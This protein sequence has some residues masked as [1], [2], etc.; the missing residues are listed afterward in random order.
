M[1]NANKIYITCF[2]TKEILRV[3]A[4][5]GYVEAR[6]P[7]KEF[8]YSLFVDKEKVISTSFWDNTPPFGIISDADP[9]QFFLSDPVSVPTNSETFTNSVVISGINSQTFASVPALYSATIIKNGVESGNKVPVV[10]GDILIV[11]FTTPDEEEK[12]IE[13]PLFVGSKY[14][15]FKSKTLPKDRLVDA[16]YF[17]DV[18]GSELNQEYVSNEITI[19]GLSNGVSVTLTAS[20]GSIILNGVSTSVS[21]IIVKNDDKVRILATTDNTYEARKFITVTCGS[22][23]NIWTLFNKA[24]TAPTDYINPII[25]QDVVLAQLDTLYQSEEKTITGLTQ[26]PIRL[27]LEPYASASI[28]K[29]GVDV[30]QYADFVVGDK[31]RIKAK[32][33][34]DGESYS[35]IGLYSHNFSTTFTIRTTADIYP[36]LFAFQ[37]IIDVIP[38]SKITSVDIY[39]ISGTKPNQT[40]QVIIAPNDIAKHSTIAP[41]LIINGVETSSNIATVKLGDTI[42]YSAVMNGVTWN[43]YKV[44][45]S[46]KTQNGFQ[47][48]TADVYTKYLSGVAIDDVIDTQS[49]DNSYGIE[50][51]LVYEHQETTDYDFTIYTPEILFG[52]KTSFTSEYEKTTQLKTLEKLIVIEKGAGV[53]TT[54]GDNP[55]SFEYKTTISS[56][57]ID[58]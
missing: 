43:G 57:I 56:E 36:D 25:I 41:T 10:D 48:A 55:L 1:N 26:N 17:D 20:F 15:W 47:F 58:S 31:F 28:I 49:I 45:L 4:I 18:I 11:K 22:Y 37:D 13:L 53:A 38:R 5:T 33:P 34:L 42:R 54:L 21:S 12:V 30:G 44:T 46:L 19:S 32:S 24:Q 51:Q 35:T 16:F 2:V 7:A 52:R 8:P 39:T 27:Y 6:I 3:D 29:N 14:D 23:L 50:S 40:F 9:N